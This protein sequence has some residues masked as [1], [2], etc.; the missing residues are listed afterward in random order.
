MLFVLAGGGLL[1][2]LWTIRNVGDF[3][4]SWLHSAYRFPLATLPIALLI[5]SAPRTKRIGKW[6]DN[7]LFNTIARLSYSAYLWHTVVIVLMTRFVFGGQH[8]LP[9]PEW[10][11]LTGAT[12]V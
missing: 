11:V 9:I 5:F 3:D 10:L 4:H 2:F 8:N 6:L 7:H 12:L 1:F